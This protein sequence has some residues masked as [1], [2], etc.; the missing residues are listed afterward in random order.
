MMVSLASWWQTIEA[1]SR[2]STSSRPWIPKTHSPLKTHVAAFDQE[3]S[4]WLGPQ[5]SALISHVLQRGTSG[6]DKATKRDLGLN[7]VVWHRNGEKK[8]CDCVHVHLCEMASD[9]LGREVL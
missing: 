1:P 2:H 5:S 9:E 6:S 7:D 3:T 8:D 4:G